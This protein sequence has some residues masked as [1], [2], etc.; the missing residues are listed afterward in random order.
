LAISDEELKD[1]S[2]PGS[3]ASGEADAAA[4]VPVKE[5]EIFD[6]KIGAVDQKAKIKV[7]KEVRAITGLG[8]K[9]VQKYVM[10][11]SSLN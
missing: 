8:L 1:T 11:F 2:G 10:L 9:E 5:K 7:I 3:S 6:I 4:A